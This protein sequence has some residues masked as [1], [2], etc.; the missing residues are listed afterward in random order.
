MIRRVDFKMVNGRPFYTIKSG[1]F[2]ISKNNGVFALESNS[3]SVYVHEDKIV[4]R[5]DSLSRGMNDDLVREFTISPKE[6]SLFMQTSKDNW[7]WFWRDKET[8]DVMDKYSI[9]KIIP[10]DPSEYIHLEQVNL[11][12]HHYSPDGEY[13]GYRIK[14][15]TIKGSQS[16]KVWLSDKVA[17]NKIEPKIITKH[18]ILG[19]TTEVILSDVYFSLDTFML[20]KNREEHQTLYINKDIPISDIDE[21]MSRHEPV[22]SDI[23]PVLDDSFIKNSNIGN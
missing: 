23:T 17:I 10:I 8:Q 13:D 16:F 14:D 18:P 9:N 1:Y 12:E 7:Y 15:S 5:C 22:F 3:W 21:Y 4:F 6:G 11:L 19:N 2:N 20:V